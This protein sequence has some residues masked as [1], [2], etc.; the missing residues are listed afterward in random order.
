MRSR[1]RRRAH[2]GDGSET[3]A[4]V[5]TPFSTRPYIPAVLGN[6]SECIVIGYTGSMCNCR[7]HDEQHQG[8]IPGWYKCAHRVYYIPEKLRQ[9]SL[10]SGSPGID[11]GM[12]TPVIQ[13]SYAISVDGECAGVSDYRQSFDS[14][15]ATVTT[16]VTLRDVAIKVTGYL[17]D[18]HVWVERIKVV[19]K[20]KNKTVDL[21]FSLDTF[22]QTGFLGTC[23][24]RQSLLKVRPKPRSGAI[25]FDYSITPNPV[26]GMGYMWAEPKG[27]VENNKIVYH[28]I[29]RG[30]T[31]TRY[32]L[33]TD[34]AESKTWR[35][36]AKSGYRKSKASTE[37]QIR[38]AHVKVWRDF[39][40]QS[41]I[42]VPDAESQGLYD[43]SLQWMRANQY[44]KNGSMNLGPYPLH[45][46]GGCN[47]IPD[48][49]SNQMALLTSNHVS[50]SRRLLDFYRERMPRARF[51]AKALGYP[52]ARL[53]Y[54]ASASGQ[55]YH[56]DPEKIRTEKV[57]ANAAACYS[58]Y[59]HWQRSG[60]DELLPESL[61]IMRELLDHALA[62]AVIEK[63]DRAYIGVTK[64]SCE[65]KFDVSNDSTISIRLVRALRGYCEMAEAAQEP[66]P[67]DYRRIAEKLPKGLRENYRNGV[68]MP[69]R[70]AK[71]H[72]AVALVDYFFNLPEGVDRKSVLYS[73]KVSSGPL[74][75]DSDTPIANIRDW[76]WSHAW[77]ALIYS[78]WGWDQKAFAELQQAMQ[79]CSALGA[80]PEKVRMDGYP[81]NHYYTST[82]A[83]YLWAFQTTLCHDRP[84]NVLALLQ[85]M[86]GT[87]RDIEFSKLRMSGG[88]LVSLEAKKGR[89]RRLVLRNAGV[90]PIERKL[91]LN[92]RYAGKVTDV[93]S[94]RPGQTKEM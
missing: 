22:T 9:A 84:D 8:L 25:E 85:G 7:G 62:V 19:R 11:T 15:T 86:D 60:R 54:F 30:F 36:D 13:A 76:P 50:E 51:V 49:W 61:S 58:F 29:Q 39:S 1:N 46:G 74:G 82:H 38:K 40:R 21:A 63:S 5:A 18:A 37:A 65:C 35:A 56:E 27:K 16:D 31:A 6:G 53:C 59:D 42:S 24:S 20:P 34:D 12:A 88:L 43:F 23:V 32:L 45:W 67:E 77:M 92:P 94:L 55:D 3:T 90:R 10:L 66:V 72:G 64:P 33:A 17:T 71:F 26:Q 14:A 47:A 78:H 87:W 69:F 70:D 93:V 73:I 80:I 83:Y 68:L 44:P 2:A 4:W 28:D 57:G 75:F 52:G 81:V 89:V 48:A 91:K 79:H 41:S